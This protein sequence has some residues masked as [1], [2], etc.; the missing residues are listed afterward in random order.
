M[1]KILSLVL[2]LCMV[3]SLTACG[4]GKITAK[5]VYNA[6]KSLAA[7]RGNHENVLIQITSNG[8]LV[9]EEYMDDQYFYSFLDSEYMEIGADNLSFATKHSEYV[10]SGDSYVRWV[11]LKP[12][13]MV[14]LKE[15]FTIVGE[16]GFLSSALQDAEPVIT[17]KDGLIFAT[18][19]YDAEEIAVIGE[20]VAS[21]EETYILDAKTREM[22]AV[23]TIY[24]FE[25]GS[26]EVGIATIT[27][28]V[29]MP[30]GMKPFIEYDQETEDLRTVTIVSNP[31][32]KNE[33]TESIQV[34]KGLKVGFI[35]DWGLTETC[36]M[37]TDAACTEVY[38]MEEISDS[39]QTVYVKWSK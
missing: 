13:G 33:K 21:C 37:Y 8:T 22:T 6:G 34:A 36:E 9:R 26:I 14:D 31:G 5:E 4:N 10:F 17:E 32:E 11:M 2:V 29:E 15:Y 1:K 3:L 16:S 28:D 7:L 25:D 27:R 19:T 38:D 23:E 18:R 24:T 20:G 35:P 12:D 30:E 39:D